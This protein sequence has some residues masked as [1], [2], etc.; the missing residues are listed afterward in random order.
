MEGLLKKGKMVTPSEAGTLLKRKRNRGNPHTTNSKRNFLIQEQNN[1]PQKVN[2]FK[3]PDID[4]NNLTIITPRKNYSNNIFISLK[5]KSS[6]K[7]KSKAAIKT[8]NQNV[9]DLMNKSKKSNENT[10]KSNMMFDNFMGWK[11]HNPIGKGLKNLGN[12]CFVN[13]VLQCILYTPPLYN[14]IILNNHEEHCTIKTVCFL[15]EYSKLVKKCMSNANTGSSNVTNQSAEI[16]NPISFIQNFIKMGK[17]FRLGKQE[18]AHEFL[19][20]LLEVMENS[21]KESME[22][23]NN[24]SNKYSTKNEFEDGN[25]IQKV[26]GGVTKSSVTCLQCRKPSDTFEKFIDTGL[27]I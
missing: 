9:E 4:S 1:F 12:T 19:L 6:E 2:K 3:I 13:S 22:G 18:D 26:Y 20:K 5:G 21:S 25:L 15:C 7:S 24:K 23:I 16:E 27:V 11:S 14:Y 10:D 17:V 8:V